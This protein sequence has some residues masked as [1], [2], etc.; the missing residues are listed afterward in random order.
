MSDEVYGVEGAFANRQLRMNVEQEKIDTHRGRSDAEQH[1]DKNHR[2]DNADLNLPRLALGGTWTA[3]NTVGGHHA[4]LAT[5]GEQDAPVEE[6]ENCKNDDVEGEKVTD[7]ESRLSR[8]TLPQECIADAVHNV[9]S[10]SVPAKRLAEKETF[11][12]T[13]SVSG[14]TLDLNQSIAAQL[15]STGSYASRDKLPNWSKSGSLCLLTDPCVYASKSAS[16]F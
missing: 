5:N 15:N 3:S 14:G 8:S 6:E 4:R 7:S 13:Y 1:T 9:A 12:I 16:M 11:N 2:L 10:S